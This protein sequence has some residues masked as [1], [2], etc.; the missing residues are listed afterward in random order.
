MN[1]SWL[2]CSSEVEEVH[3]GKNMR[4]SWMRKSLKRPAQHE[5]IAFWPT[6]RKSEIKRWR[7]KRMTP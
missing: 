4:E 2:E 3:V 7:N 6:E 5:I 1:K